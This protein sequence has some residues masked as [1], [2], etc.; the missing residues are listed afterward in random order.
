MTFK[1]R[2]AEATLASVDEYPSGRG[3]YNVWKPVAVIVQGV[4]ASLAGWETERN[5]IPQEVHFFGRPNHH[6][7]EIGDADV[8]YTY[9]MK[10]GDGGSG[11]GH[12]VPPHREGCPEPHDDSSSYEKRKAIVEDLAASHHNGE[13][14]SCY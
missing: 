11:M 7:F 2:L 3:H 10:L 8:Y 6:A 14:T 4:R 13:A 12:L 5:S 1:L 9:K